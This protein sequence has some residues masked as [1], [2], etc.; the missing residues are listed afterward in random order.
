[1]SFTTLGTGSRES[2]V[3]GNAAHLS[4][5]G[6]VLRH[7]ISATGTAPAYSKVQTIG[8]DRA[9]ATA[10]ARAATSSGWKGWCLLPSMFSGTSR[11]A[12]GQ[13]SISHGVE[14]TIQLTRALFAIQ[15]ESARS[16]CTFELVDQVH[17]ATLDVKVGID[18][19]W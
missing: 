5:P 1:M 9:V 17:A 18:L 16:P 2:H 14:S 4:E 13:V 12:M 11:F 6:A 19:E 8:N 15:S 7:E 3:D 10:L